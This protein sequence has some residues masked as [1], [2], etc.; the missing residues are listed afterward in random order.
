[1]TAI[2]WDMAVVQ[3]RMADVAMMKKACIFKTETIRFADWLHGG[4][5]G[6]GQCTCHWV[7]VTHCPV[8]GP[9][10]QCAGAPGTTTWRAGGTPRTSTASS[11]FSMRTWRRWGPDHLTSP[12]LTINASVAMCTP[13]GTLRLQ[14]G[15]GGAVFHWLPHPPITAHLAHHEFPYHNLTWAPWNSGLWDTFS[16]QAED[17]KHEWCLFSPLAVCI[18]KFPLEGKNFVVHFVF[19]FISARGMTGFQE[20]V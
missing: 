16:L 18:L 12:H 8:S 17:G 10:L 13:L 14:S 11:T 6:G 20:T 15:T 7:S 5:G 3:T 2:Q 19:F 4:R 9:I 1:M